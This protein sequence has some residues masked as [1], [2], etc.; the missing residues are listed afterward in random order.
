VEVSDHPLVPGRR[1]ELAV[2][3]RGPTRL[4]GV[5]VELVCEEVATYQA[6]TSQ[7]TAR[8][9]VARHPLP[10]DR[11]T[12]GPPL[13]FALDVPPGGMHSFE[14]KNNKIRWLIRVSGR[15]FGVLP[16]TGDFATVVRPG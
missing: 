4:G 5:R 10:A 16:Y 9:V 7:S 14:A 6:G 12:G 2:A 11:D 1:Y 8:R 15:V 13:S 3:Q